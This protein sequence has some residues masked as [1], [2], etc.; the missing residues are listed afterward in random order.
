MLPAAFGLFGAELLFFAVADDAETIGGNT[1]RDQRGAGSVGAILAEGKVVLGRPSVIA[2]AADD[3]F[4]GW[5][6]GE[7]TGGLG[8]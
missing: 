7:V 3:D 6:G 1:G 2:V 5:M 4:D 8:D